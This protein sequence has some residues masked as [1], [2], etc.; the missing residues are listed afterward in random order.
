MFG[1]T[2]FQGEKLDALLPFGMLA[3][4]LQNKLI[5]SVFHDPEREFE[6]S[7]LVKEW[8]AQNLDKCSDAPRVAAALAVIYSE[9]VFKARAETL[10][11]EGEGFEAL[12]K[13]IGYQLGLDIDPKTHEYSPR[14][15]T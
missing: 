4:T 13:G 2:V 3:V 14:V 8:Q 12:L 10:A 11:T 6:S 7:R 1:S 5:V 9:F 15:T